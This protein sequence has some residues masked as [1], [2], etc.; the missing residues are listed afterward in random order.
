MVFCLTQHCHCRI[1]NSILPT[2]VQSHGTSTT[3][4]TQNLYSLCVIV[5]FSSAPAAIGVADRTFLGIEPVCDYQLPY[6]LTLFAYLGQ[7]SDLCGNDPQNCGSIPGIPFTR[8]CV[9]QSVPWRK[10]VCYDMDRSTNPLELVENYME[11]AAN[12]TASG[13]TPLHVVTKAYGWRTLGEP[14]FTNNTA[15]VAQIAAHGIFADY[16]IQDEDEYEFDQRFPTEHPG[17]PYCMGGCGFHEF[18]G[19]DG[20]CYQRSCQNL[21]DFGPYEMV[22][23]N[24]TFPKNELVCTDNELQ[25]IEV[26]VECAGNPRTEWPIATFFQ[27]QVANVLSPDVDLDIIEYAHDNCWTPDLDNRYVAFDRMCTAKNAEQEFECYEIID[28]MASSQTY[29]QSIAPFADQCDANALNDFYKEEVFAGQQNL[30]NDEDVVLY[31]GRSVYGSCTRDIVFEATGRVGS[32]GFC[33]ITA[34]PFCALKVETGRLEYLIY[35]QVKLV[36]SSRRLLSP[37]WSVGTL[38]TMSCLLLWC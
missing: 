18:C 21:Y 26:G 17:F 1:S 14:L 22:N 13:L 7:D 4:F 12:L 33:D 31:N 37:L 24:E 34:G 20:N 10:F 8:K 25:S 30:V 35:S 5:P 19:R 6:G 3:L 11:Y 15:E 38:V 36:S 16:D 2:S 29:L 23:Y 32:E 9:A 28:P 27:C